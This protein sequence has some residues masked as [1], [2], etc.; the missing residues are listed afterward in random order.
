[1][2]KSTVKVY[3]VRNVYGVLCQGLDYID[4]TIAIT[5]NTRMLG[6]HFGLSRSNVFQHVHESAR[7]VV[8]FLVSQIAGLYRVSNLLLR[9]DKCD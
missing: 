3:A 9:V 8:K 4:G 2:L 6:I 1:M 7:L 5:I